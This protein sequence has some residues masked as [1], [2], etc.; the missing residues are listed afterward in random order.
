MQ[1]P[2]RY[3]LSVSAEQLKVLRGAVDRALNVPFSKH[4]AETEGRWAAMSALKGTDILSTTSPN[5]TIKRRRIDMRTPHPVKKRPSGKSNWPRSQE[6]RAR[7]AAR[8]AERRQLGMSRWETDR[9]GLGRVSTPQDG[10]Y[11]P[12]DAEREALVALTSELSMRIGADVLKPTAQ[13]AMVAADA[14]S[15]WIKA[16]HGGRSVEVAFHTGTTAPQFSTR[17]GELLE[18]LPDLAVGE[19]LVFD[20][21]QMH[22]QQAGDWRITVTFESS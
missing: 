6:A 15:D 12:S 20:G 3:Q 9:T 21:A 8:T 11:V 17:E 16:R 14:W 1:E 4:K 22:R 13:A 2:Q 10:R 19:A 5:S 18:Q 7:L